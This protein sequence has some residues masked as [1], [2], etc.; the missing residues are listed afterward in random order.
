MRDVGFSLCHRGDWTEGVA[1]LRQSLNV[2]R[3]TGNRR[4]EAWALQFL[5]GMS[6]Y[7]GRYAQAQSY[8]EQGLRYLLNNL[9]EA[10]PRRT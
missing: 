5:G 7:Q 10:V 2:C 1:Y 4:D 9:G 8:I 6:N 3:E